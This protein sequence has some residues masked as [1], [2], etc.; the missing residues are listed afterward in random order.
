MIK[1][2]LKEV[3]KLDV[4]ILVFNL[5][6][7]IKYLQPFLYSFVQM[8]ISVWYFFQLEKTTLISLSTSLLVN[9]PSFCL[10]EIFLFCFPEIFLFLLFGNIFSDINSRLYEF[11]CVSFSTLKMSLYFLSALIVSRDQSVES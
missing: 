7:T 3:K 11:V 9:S 10:P 1:C 8:H 5:N 6:F 4:S 2:L